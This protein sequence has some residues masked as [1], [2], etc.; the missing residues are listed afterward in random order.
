MKA[1]NRKK[2]KVK[3]KTMNRKAIIK[4]TIVVIVLAIALFIIL[5]VMVISKIKTLVPK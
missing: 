1:E 4:E 3:C 2:S 5:M